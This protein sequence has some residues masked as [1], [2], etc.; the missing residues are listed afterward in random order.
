[1]KKS[2]L[3]FALICVPFL[4]FS[5]AVLYHNAPSFNNATSGTRAPNGTAAHTYFRGSTI[6]IAPEFLGGIPSSSNITRFGFMYNVGASTAATGTLKV[7]MMNTT[8]ISYLNGTSWATIIASMTLVYDGPYTIPSGAVPIATDVTLTAPF[9][10]TGGGIYVAYDWVLTGTAATTGA[11]YQSNNAI[12]TSVYSG[13]STT[14]APA[15]ITAA[16]GFRPVMRFGYNNPFTNDG[17]VAQVYTLGKLPIPSG[18]PHA[19]QA[20]IKNKGSEILLNTPV[21][22]TISGANTFSNIKTIDTIQP[23][24]QKLVTFDVFNPTSVGDNSVTVSVP[25]DQNNIN[26]SMSKSLKTNPNTYSYSQGN[27]SDGGVGFNTSTGDFVAKF[28]TATPESMNQ[29]DVRFTSGNKPFQ[30][31]IWSANATGTPDTLIYTSATYTS[32]AGAFT[33]LIDPPVAIPAGSFFVGVRQTAAENIG[34]AYQIESPI[35]PNSFFYA[36]PSGG[37]T[38][39]DFAPANEFRFMIEPKFALAHDVSVY[40]LAP[41]ASD[42]HLAGQPINIEATKIGRAHV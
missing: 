2:L 27:V 15:T 6:A 36:S 21:T 31:G 1:M 23:G 13:G 5:Q 28:T 39:N 12:G 25:S 16:S 40:A 22:L 19:V 37:T 3:F 33:V 32:V 8:D 4:L 24:M 42:I 38:W 11:V 29:V 35:R 18:N 30:I 20:Y 17:L 41:S 7:Y 9:A 26:N 14:A 34:F 10:Y